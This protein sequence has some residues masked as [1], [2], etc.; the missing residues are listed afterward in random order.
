MDNQIEKLLKMLKLWLAK[1]GLDGDLSFY[2]IEK[3]RQRKEPYLNEAEMVITTEGQLNFII[4]YNNGAEIHEEFEELLESFGYY[5]EL[6]YSWSLGIYKIDEA[7]RQNINPSY[8]EKLK[9][10]RWIKKRE[11]VRNRA[12][13]QCEDCGAMDKGLEIH[14]CYYLYGYEPW[15]YPT[16]S[17][18]CLCKPCHKTRDPIEKKHRGQLA[19]LTQNEVETLNTIFSNG[20]YWYPRKELFDFINNIGHDEELMK[21][22]LDNLILKRRKTHD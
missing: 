8:S 7:K 13:N 15:E 16:D 18:R 10:E 5:Y 4:N 22:S 3:W 12:G 19:H 11:L 20:L 9:D 1:N 21:K 2:T 6:G 17:L 14:H